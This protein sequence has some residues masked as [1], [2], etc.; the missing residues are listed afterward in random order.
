MRTNLISVKLWP[1]LDILILMSPINH[2]QI[3]DHKQYYLNLALFLCSDIYENF[4][5]IYRF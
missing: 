1:L 2:R 3:A 5:K 4:T